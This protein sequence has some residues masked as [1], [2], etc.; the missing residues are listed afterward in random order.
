[1]ILPFCST[2]LRWKTKRY[3]PLTLCRGIELEASWR[4]SNYLEYWTSESLCMYVLNKYPCV[5]VCRHLC[6][7]VCINTF[8]FSVCS[9]NY[10]IISRSITSILN[11]NAC[12][13]KLTKRYFRI[14]NNSLIRLKYLLRHVS[15]MCWL[16]IQTSVE[17]LTS[18]TNREQIAI[19]SVKILCC[20]ICKKPLPLFSSWKLC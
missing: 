2:L 3:L 13:W 15:N 12:Y 14:W 20:C 10:L 6:N 17:K 8:V 19:S 1:M 9:F 11:Q 4:C 7:Y 16:K 5:H 18:A